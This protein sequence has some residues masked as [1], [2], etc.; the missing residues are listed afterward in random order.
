MRINSLAFFGNKE[1]ESVGG[2]A[3]QKASIFAYM[4]HATIGKLCWKVVAQ[5]LKLF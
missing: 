3:A 5:A 1:L 4:N 2:F